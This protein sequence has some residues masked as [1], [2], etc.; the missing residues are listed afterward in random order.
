MAKGA[1]CQKLL[2]WKC[3]ICHIGRNSISPI[4]HPIKV[5][6]EEIIYLFGRKYC[7]HLHVTYCVAPPSGENANRKWQCFQNNHGT[8][9]DT[10]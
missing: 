10:P 1:M 6:M 5:K 8:V 3:P 9:L 2:R 7:A 4:D